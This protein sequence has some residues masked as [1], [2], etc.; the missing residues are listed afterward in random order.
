MAVREQVEKE[1]CAWGGGG[2]KMGAG[3]GEWKNRF[4]P[5]PRR[6]KK[7]K[8]GHWFNNGEQKDFLREGAW[9][10]GNSVCLVE[11]IRGGGE[12]KKSIRG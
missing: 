8:R 7:E 6:G 3:E 5:K 2:T 10:R 4:N 1:K 9:D 11:I 12:P